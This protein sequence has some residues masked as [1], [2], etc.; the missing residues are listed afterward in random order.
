MSA[1]ST[2]TELICQTRPCNRAADHLLFF[3]CH[4]SGVSPQQ[5]KGN[6]VT[7]ISFHVVH[8]H[9]KN[10]FLF[11]L[12]PISSFLKWLLHFNHF[13]KMDGGKIAKM[14]ETAKFSSTIN[15]VIIGRVG[16]DNQQSMAGRWPGITV[17]CHSN[18][19]YSYCRQ[20]TLAMWCY[21]SMAFIPV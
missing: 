13:R 18:Q 6:A 1:S 9:S 20:A 15:A 17:F 21:I 3:L 10:I 7:L 16:E 2:L 11:S 4:V 5:P 12:A 14:Q 19:Y 8:Q